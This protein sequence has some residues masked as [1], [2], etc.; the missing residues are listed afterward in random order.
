MSVITLN[1]IGVNNTETTFVAEFKQELIFK[2]VAANGNTTFSY[3]KG[4]VIANRYVI[5]GE[6]PTK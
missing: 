5:K 3:P 1:I 2:A 6:L 4:S